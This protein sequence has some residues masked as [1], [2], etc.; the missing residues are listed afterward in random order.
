MSGAEAAL[1]LGL[2][3]ATIT[4]VDGATQVYQA[5]G[6]VKGLPEAFGEVD[7]RLPLV[8]D[9]LRRAKESVERGDVDNQTC[10]AVEPV[11]TSCKQKADKLHHLFQEVLPAQGA[12][13]KERYLKAIKTLGKGNR[14]EQLMKGTLED[15]QLLTGDRGMMTATS[16]DI[17]RLVEAVQEISALPPSLDDHLLDSPASISMNYHGSGPQTAYSAGRDQFINPG[18]G[19][20]YHAERM[21]FGGDGKE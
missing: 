9:I 18:S 4:I 21:N 13:R 6:N 3:S 20:M 5:A 11:I 8:Q 12:S 10:K 2:I 1:I 14:V 16:A 7:K 19:R 17:D 15:V